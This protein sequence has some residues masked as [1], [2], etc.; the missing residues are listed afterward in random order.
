VA[1]EIEWKFNNVK[2]QILSPH[3]LQVLN[4]HMRLVVSILMAKMETVCIVMESAVG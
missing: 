1:I 4:S 2:I 3:T